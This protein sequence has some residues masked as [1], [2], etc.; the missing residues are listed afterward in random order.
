MSKNANVFSKS[1]DIILTICYN[2][3]VTIIKTIK[4]EIDIMNSQ[5]HG[6]N[7]KVSS[8]HHSIWH[9]T[10]I[11]TLAI[12]A[13]ANL[14]A[15]FTGAMRFTTVLLV[16]F[17]MAVITL[18]VMIKAYFVDK[19]HDGIGSNDAKYFS[20]FLRW[21]QIQVAFIVGCLAIAFVGLIVAALGDN[22]TAVAVG[23]ERQTYDVTSGIGTLF[24]KGMNKIIN[25]IG[26]L[27]ISGP[28]L[29]IGAILLVLVPV[30]F[31]CINLVFAFTNACGCYETVLT[32]KGSYKPYAVHLFVLGGL[33][34]VLGIFVFEYLGILGFMIAATQGAYSI[35]MGILLK[36][37]SK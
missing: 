7:N 31:W 9:L 17:C 5:N 12:Y 36:K 20:L 1:I 33:D 6:G 22:S 11:I 28:A 15:L 21:R 25:I 34:I 19:D 10:M 23:I 3:Y 32:K 2:I 35:L 4:K 37:Y 18:F 30:V 24:F 26:N 16:S 8:A 29:M 14:V 27:G 13:L